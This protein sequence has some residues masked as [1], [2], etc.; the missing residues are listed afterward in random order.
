MSLRIPP[1]ENPE[2]PY[3]DTTY[4]GRKFKALISFFCAGCGYGSIAQILNRIYADN[5]LDENKFPIVNG[6][7]CYTMIPL[8]LP[9]KTFMCLHGRGPAV[10]TGIKLANPEMKPISIQ[11][12]GDALSIGTN[13]FIHAARRNVDMVLLLLHNKIYGMTGGQV[14]PTTPE[15][16]KASTAPYGFLES[17]ID[18]AK[19]AIT[20]GA[21]FV[22][23]WT[24]AHPRQFMKSLTKAL[25]EH[26]GFSLIEIVSQCPTYFGRRN[27][28]GD[29]V[30]LYN[31]IKDNS[32]HLNKAKSM[33][34]EELKDKIVIG[35][36]HEERR[37]TLTEKYM[38]LIDTLD[39][40]D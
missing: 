30:E 20:A 28:M 19:L 17:T 33:S 37:P 25:I 6:V 32:I 7:G 27:D 9:G 13:H 22:A 23:R 11:G 10:A 3:A 26:K 34:D 40:G 36:F 38:K 31:W 24:T 16:W 5:N 39:K 8:I 4:V 1:K 29:P 15:N 35:E 18:A 12:D 14:A 2:H 21:T